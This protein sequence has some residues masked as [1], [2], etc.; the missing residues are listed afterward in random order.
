MKEALT[1]SG[2]KWCTNEVDAFSAIRRTTLKIFYPN[3]PDVSFNK[4]RPEAEALIAAGLAKPWVN[5]VRVPNAKFVV[6]TDAL[7][8]E[9]Y[10]NSSCGTCGNRNQHY[11]KTAHLTQQFRHCGV[12]DAV[13]EQVGEEY[14]RRRNAWKPTPKPALTQEELDACLV[15]SVPLNHFA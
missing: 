15:K 8:F 11:G 4:P 7:T 13:P 1:P 9:P 12:V 5:P 3:R 10:I 14:V 6:C 2:K